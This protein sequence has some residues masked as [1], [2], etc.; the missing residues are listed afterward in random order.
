MG[1]PR[2]PRP[3]CLTPETAGPALPLSVAVITLNEEEN[4]DR[5]LASVAGLAREIVVVDSGST[6]GTRRVA[7]RY[8]ARF[9][10]N[11][12]PGHVKQKN[13]ALT[14]CGQPWV[15]SLDADEALDE[16]L[17][18]DIE[19]LLAGK[20]TCEGYALN[21]LTWYLGDW[22]RHAWYPEW[23]LR[24]VR[25]EG[26]EW[27][28]TDPHDHL[29]VS[30][31]IGRLEGHLLHY[32]YRDL[33]HHLQQT[34]HYGRISGLQVAARGKHI[35]LGKL[36]LSPLGRFMR[37]LVLKGGWRDGWRGVLIA[38]SSM[39]AGFAKY[40]FAMERQRGPSG[41]DDDR[42]AGNQ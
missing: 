24:L 33:R 2:Q 14:S 13:V 18:S 22:I 23:R 25:R 9:I 21:R 32:S 4:L 15:L 36:L 20:P 5:C 35:G 10:Y 39:L 8:C 42:D 34:L 11:D 6:D 41:S 1:I 28:G 29:H 30:G 26:A 12:W 31:R 17:R 7:E 27:T 38:G 16:R 37:I 3:V 40:A 19:S